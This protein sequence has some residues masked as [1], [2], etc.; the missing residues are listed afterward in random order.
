MTA[1]S[2]EKI[3]HHRDKI[4][5]LKSD[6]QTVPLQ[7]HLIISDLCNQDC[8]FCAYRMSGYTTNELFKIVHPESG[9]I[10]NNPNRKIPYEKC[11]EIL[12]DC[13]EMG[14]KAIQIT[15]GGEPSVHPDHT[16][17]YQAVL[18]RGMELAL[19]S[20]GVIFKEET[21]PILLKASWVRF[22][23]DA[24]NP[25]SYTRIRNVSGK[26][27]E[28]VWK[29][30]S[31]L[32]ERKRETKSNVTIGMGFVVTDDNWTEIEDF[33]ILAKN[34]GVDNVRISAVFQPDN[35][36]YFS[37]FFDQASE[38]CRKTKEKHENKDFTIFNNFGERYG[39][40]VQASPDYSFCGYQ[41][42]V[43]YIGGDLNVYRCCVTAYNKQGLI[44]SITD[45]RFKELW[46]SEEKRKNFES[47]DAKSCERCM[48][49]NK[50]KTILYAINSSPQHVNFI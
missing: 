15:G 34:A 44:G 27:Y 11:I 2:S 22:S 10:N 18:D 49:N 8:K 40:L 5:Q 4:D 9:E 20:N 45:K 43:T 41:Q 6:Q 30:V 17:I 36:K 26:H 19:V 35:E 25:K 7:V 16:R 29:N 23:V 13:K 3:F 50:N 46:E 24:G 32:A 37:Q 31:S 28:R 14:V 1:Y 38:L 33:V 47:F 39:D 42:L 48:F 12:D 21:I